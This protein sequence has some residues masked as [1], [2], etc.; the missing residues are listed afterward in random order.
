MSDRRS[1]FGAGQIY[2]DSMLVGDLERIRQ[3]FDDMDSKR[4]LTDLLKASDEAEGVK[5]FIGSESNLSSLSGSSVIVAPYQDSRQ[6]VVGAIG[7]V[8][9]TYLNYARIVPMVDFTAK[10]IS[11]IV[12]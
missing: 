1:L 12:G 9:P 7:V 5:I 3:L 2:D 10:V 4:A 6:Q 8:G 11:R